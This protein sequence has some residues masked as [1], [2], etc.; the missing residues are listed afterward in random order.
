MDFLKRQQHTSRSC[1]Y[2]ME[3]SRGAIST[4][5]ETLPGNAVTNP[6][7]PP[8]QAQSIADGVAGAGGEGFKI[9]LERQLT[10]PATWQLPLDLVLVDSSLLQLV[11]RLQVIR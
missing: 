1:R 4:A 8:V 5:E 10:E 6:A 2:G 3:E 7:K 11:R 9:D